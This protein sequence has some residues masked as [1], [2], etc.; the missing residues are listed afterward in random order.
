MTV[1]KII[2]AMIKTDKTLLRI[3]NL[4]ME[5]SKKMKIKNR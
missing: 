1:Q 2:F 3:A 4:K 5:I